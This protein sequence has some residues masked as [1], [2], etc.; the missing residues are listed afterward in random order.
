MMAKT[1]DGIATSRA[2]CAFV[3]V[4]SPALFTPAVKTPEQMGW[5]NGVCRYRETARRLDLPG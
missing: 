2:Q 3:M 1:I 4:A 5:A